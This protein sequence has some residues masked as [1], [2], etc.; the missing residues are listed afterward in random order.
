[1]VENLKKSL[2][3]ICYFLISS[4]WSQNNANDSLPVNS[5]LNQQY[6]NSLRSFRGKL[7]KKKYKHIKALIENEL[8]TKISD[9]KDILINYFQKAPNCISKRSNVEYNLT[10]IDNCIRISARICKENNAV[11]F[12]VFS[13]DSFFKDLCK[14]KK[15]FRLDSGFFYKTIF[16]LHENCTAFFILKANG[17]FYKYYGEDY[18]DEVKRYL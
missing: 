15:Q 5:E 18:F 12:F 13:E 16:T 1:M 14:T 2:Y 3:I 17:K 9:R 4:C 6:L 10:F 11:D 7:D 8:N